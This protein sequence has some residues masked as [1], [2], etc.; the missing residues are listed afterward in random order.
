MTFYPT[1][2]DEFI[3]WA[4]ALS[5]Y[6]NKTTNGQVRIGFN[7]LAASMARTLPGTSGDFNINTLKAL[8]D[9]ASD[10]AQAVPEHDNNESVRH[11]AAIK[12]T[13]HV[14][15]RAIVHA[16]KG[17]LVDYEAPECWEGYDFSSDGSD[18]TLRLSTVVTVRARSKDEAI[19]LA[20][21]DAPSLELTYDQANVDLWV[22]VNYDDDVWVESD[23]ETIA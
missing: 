18:A 12:Q 20:K 3:A 1:T 4:K 14:V 19:E 21:G 23:S 9:N 8:L 15:V 5:L 22:D 16:D 11:D 10:A 2:H 6:L 7:R 17:F 13:F